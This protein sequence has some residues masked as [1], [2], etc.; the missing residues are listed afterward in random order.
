MG[1]VGGGHSGLAVGTG[2][3]IG[4]DVETE[5]GIDI[6]M[7]SGG[8]PWRCGVG[9]GQGGRGDGRRETS[10]RLRHFRRFEEPR[11]RKFAKDVVQWLKECCVMCVRMLVAGLT[12]LDG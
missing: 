2:T 12:G 1:Y 7:E 9:V 8:T 3:D 11:F 10:L 5:A 6:G 4:V